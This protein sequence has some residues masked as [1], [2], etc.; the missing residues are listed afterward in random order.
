MFSGSGAACGSPGTATPR[1]ELPLPLDG[2]LLLTGGVLL[3]ATL[4]LT[5]APPDAVGDATVVLTLLLIPLTDGVPATLAQAVN[6]AA[7]T[8]APAKLAAT[9]PRP[10]RDPTPLESTLR[11]PTRSPMTQQPLFL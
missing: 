3:P 10:T 1:L 11:K 8:T 7:R 6:A 9:L 4:P 5:G 2:V